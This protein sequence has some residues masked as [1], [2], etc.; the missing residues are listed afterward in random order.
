MNKR[1]NDWHSQLT[2]GFINRQQTTQLTQR[3]HTGALRVQRALYP[4]PQYPE[5]QYPESQNDES[6]TLSTKQTGICHVMVLYPPA[7]IATGDHLKINID[8]AENTHA[9]LTTTGAGKWYGRG[10]GENSDRENNKENASESHASEQYASQKVQINLDKHA[11]CEWLP[12]ESIVYN[13]AYLQAQTQ[14]DLAENSSLLTWDIVVFGRQAYQEKFVQGQYHNQLRIYREGKLIVYEQVNQSADSR[15]FASPLAMN[16]KHVMGTFWAVPANATLDLAEMVK[17]LRAYIDSEELD[18]YC[19]HTPHAICIR[20]LG[21][22]VAGCFSAFSQL[23]H[24]LRKQWWQL[25]EHNPRIW[26]T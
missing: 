11:R 24:L 13:Q 16:G 21:D 26:A 7:G 15:W 22:D 17:Q 5:P 23:R 25:A 12:Q 18:V 6:S 8:L 14:F 2:L 4:E 3:Q 19:T 10:S 9:L 1:A 20:Y